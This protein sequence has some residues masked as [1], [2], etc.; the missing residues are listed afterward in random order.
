MDLKQFLSSFSANPKKVLKTVLALSAVLLVM[1]LLMVSQIQPGNSPVSSEDSITQARADSIRSVLS[2][3]DQ[4]RYTADDR[5]GNIFMNALTTFLVLIALLGAAWLWSRT[6]P[7]TK[8][9]KEF[10][11]L[12]SQLLGQNAQLKI[13]EINNEVWVIGVTA[14]SVNLLHRYDKEEWTA[15]PAESSSSDKKSFYEILKGKQ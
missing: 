3:S 2:K 9:N 6:K 14:N 8:D 11:E 5:S 4:G 12:G 15:K 13:M 7:Q 1:W 10:N